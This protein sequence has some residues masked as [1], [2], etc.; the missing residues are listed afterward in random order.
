MSKWIENRAA[1]FT[2]TTRSGIP[3]T[4]SRNVFKT[5]A[6]EVAAAD[7]L[8][9]DDWQEVDYIVVS[10]PFSGRNTLEVNMDLAINIVENLIPLNKPTIVLTSTGV[11]SSAAGTYSEESALLNPPLK[12]VEDLFNKLHK[13]T[14]LRLAGLMGAERYLSRYINKGDQEVVNHIHYEDVHQV[15]EWVY[16]ENKWNETYNVVAPLHPTKHQ[17]IS[18]E[19]EGILVEDE[20]LQDHRTISSKKLE[21]EGYIFKHSNP[22]YFK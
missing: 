3:S 10:V 9:Y 4:P 8:S 16:A 14:I 12:I 19:M 17:L 20:P 21:K 7:K 5:I 15:I 13:V 1:K 11:Y 2:I 6:Y 18:Y 22:L